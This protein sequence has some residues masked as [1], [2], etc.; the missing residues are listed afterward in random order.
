MI[1]VISKKPNHSNER[2]VG[3]LRL[4]ADV[5][6]STIAQAEVCEL[7]TASENKFRMLLENASDAILISKDVK[8]IE[9]NAAFCELYGYELHEIPRLDAFTLAAPETR[10]QIIRRIKTRFD[11]SYE[12]RAVKKSGEIFFVEAVG[13]TFSINGKAIRVTTSRDVS[14]KKRI[15]EALRPSAQAKSL[16]LAHM[17]QELRAPLNGTVGL[18]NLLLETPLSREQRN[19]AL[20]LRRSSEDLVGIVN[21]ILDFTK[22][23][24]KKLTINLV[25]IDLP[26]LVDEVLGLLEVEAAKKS[27]AVT[28]EIAADLPRLLRGDPLR[29]KQVLLNLLHNA[30]KFTGRGSVAVRVSGRSGAVRFTVTYTGPAFP[31]SPRTFRSRRSGS[32]T[33][34]P[35]ERPAARAS[36]F[37]SRRISWGPWAGR[38]ASKTVTGSAR[39]SGSSSP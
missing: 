12:T 20:L 35:P 28:R 13:K 18:T 9:A 21:D 34:R 33:R 38:S 27:L 23:E 25:A 24:E 31:P 4:V 29:L 22:L 37:R 36:S 30:V 17:S 5:L 11:D 15:E 6:E 7:L 26:A 39:A 14:A 1:K 10:D 8:G 16:L 32:S 19:Y 2:E 3:L